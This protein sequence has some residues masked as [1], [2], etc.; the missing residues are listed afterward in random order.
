M[1]LDI[2][3]AASL[4]RSVLGLMFLMHGWNHGFGPGGIDGTAGWFGGLGLRPARFHA[5]TSTYL[6]LGVGGAL[7]AGFLLPLAAAGAIGIMVT[8]GVIAHRSNGFFVFRDGYEY[9]LVVAVGVTALA[10]LGAGR[11]SLDHVIGFNVQ[12]WQVGIA[13][14]VAGSLGSAAMLAAC[15]RP[16]AVEAS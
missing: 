11:W 9:V 15:W 5:L 13:A 10:M 1:N 2:D 7:L 14:L 3:I 4:L 8:A 16:K 6:E 12:G